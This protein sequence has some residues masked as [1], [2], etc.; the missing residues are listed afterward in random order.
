MLTLD[1][2]SNKVDRW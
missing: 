1:N 2:S